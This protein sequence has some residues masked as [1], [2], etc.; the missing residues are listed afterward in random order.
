MISQGVRC[1]EFSRQHR[2]P[3][4]LVPLDTRWRCLIAITSTIATVVYNPLHASLDASSLKTRLHPFYTAVY[5][6]KESKWR[7]PHKSFKYS[8]SAPLQPGRERGRGD[9]ARAPARPHPRGNQLLCA[10]ELVEVK[11]VFRLP[12]STA[13]LTR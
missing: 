7:V 1:R 13:Q 6:C 10:L 12:L 8:V 11:Y 3:L 9:D 2:D 5:L 4:Q